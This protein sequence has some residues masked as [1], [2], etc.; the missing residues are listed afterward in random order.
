MENVSQ[1]ILRNEAR[2]PAGSMLLINPPRD[3]LAQ[4][5]LRA[6]RAVRCVTQD[7]GDWRWLQETGAD[8]A[9][10]AVP[11]L[12]GKEQ[13]VVLFLPREKDRLTMLLHAISNSLGPQA[14]LWL[15]GENRGGIKS[16][17]RHVRLQFSRVTA[18][19]NARHC[20]L[21][22]ASGPAPTR[23]FDLADYS[24]T[25]SMSYA[26]REIALRSLPGVFAH[27]RLDKGSSLLLDELEKLNPQG[28]V[29]DF[30]CGCG[31][32]GLAL[33]SAAPR[34]QLTLLDSSALALEASR[35]SL[36]A[37][38]LK[39]ELLASDGLAEVSGRYDWIVSNPPFH[40][41]VASDLET[42]REFFRQAGTFLAEN[43]RIVV[44]FNRHLPYLK[45]LNQSFDVVACLT[46][47]GEYTVIMAG[48][49]RKSGTRLNKRAAP[50]SLRKGKTEFS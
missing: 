8:V 35:L 27:G 2:L 1:L 29:L 39:A 11:T 26:G 10:E 25:W 32:V 30:A 22:E 46:E 18:L 40:R 13:T 3:A 20:G 4:Q 43:G 14:R 36:E 12:E 34:A 24:T 41:G 49:R 28:E 47:N 38:G 15:A 5:L 33:L 17:P 9:F 48:V 37:N 7:F 50:G 19:D 42:A 21:F 44:V 6:D 23:P 31:V 16:S 45:W